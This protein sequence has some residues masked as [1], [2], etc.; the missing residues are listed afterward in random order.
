MLRSVV[1]FLVFLALILVRVKP[2]LYAGASEIVVVGGEF[3]HEEFAFAG[4]VFVVVIAVVV[5]FGGHFWWIDEAHVFVG[6]G[7][8]R[9]E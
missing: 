1:Q 9:S 5:E 3:G 4:C 7:G 2:T 8:R 6:M